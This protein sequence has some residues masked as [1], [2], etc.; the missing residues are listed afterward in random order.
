[1]SPINGYICLKPVSALLCRSKSHGEIFATLKDEIKLTKFN[2]WK[3][4]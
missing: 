3:P 4:D 2:F 1:M